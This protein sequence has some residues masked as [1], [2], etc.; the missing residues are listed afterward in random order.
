VNNDTAQIDVSVVI[1]VCER[2]EHTIN[3]Y[4]K[5][6]TALESCDRSFEF[7]FVLIPDCEAL[8]AQLK[9]VLDQDKRA[10]ILVLN[11]NFGE[12]T[13]IQVGTDNAKGDLILI[14]PA[15]EQVRSDCLPSLFD[16]IDDYDMVV[17]KRSPRIDGRLNRMQANLFNSMIRLFTDV[18]F[19]DLGCGVRLVRKDVL[20]ELNIYGDQH[21][22][23]PLIANGQ[24]FRVEEV[25]LPQAEA[26]AHR[27]IYSPGIY[28]RR[29]LDLLTIV[30]LT[31]FNKKPLRFFGLIGT[32]SALFGALG[33]LL[34]TVQKLFFD[35]GAGDRPLLL[36]SALFIVLGV[37][38]IAIGLVGE[39]I[40]FTH[41]KDIKEY[42]VREIVN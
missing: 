31:K 6:K 10:S 37:Q 3:N 5:Y 29:L 16:H 41:A 17:A 25:D 13:A 4:Q 9:P 21:R 15:Y 20:M 30:F 14:L 35:I 42:K 23:L 38:L 12:A 1:P 18:Q 27:R 7:I 40:I 32:G 33:L 8:A 19:G 28:I 39:T 22:F 26:D 24:G 2:H 11:K 34:V 36:V